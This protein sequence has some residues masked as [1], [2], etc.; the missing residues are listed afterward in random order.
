MSNPLKNFRIRLKWALRKISRSQK[1]R[2]SLQKEEATPEEQLQ[3]LLWEETPEENLNPEQSGTPEQIPEENP[4]ETPEQTPEQ[5]N[6]QQKKKAPLWKLLFK[7]TISL[8]E[9]YRLIRLLISLIRKNW[10]GSGKN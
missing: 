10:E 2:K 1:S 6:Q 7:L 5:S 3:N 8:T 9:L 4:N